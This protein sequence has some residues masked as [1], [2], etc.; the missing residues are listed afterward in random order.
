V[1]DDAVRRL[2]FD[3]V[4]ELYGV[5]LPEDVLTGAPS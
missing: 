3:N 4:V 5:Q 2:T 1:P